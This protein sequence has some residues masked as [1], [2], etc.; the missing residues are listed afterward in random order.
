MK[1]CRCSFCILSRALHFPS[2][3]SDCNQ[4][5]GRHLTRHIR[6]REAQANVNRAESEKDR[7][8]TQRVRGNNKQSERVFLAL[9]FFADELHNSS[10]AP[11]KI[12]SNDFN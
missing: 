10:S 4:S 3:A 8:S 6:M 1:C 11:K 12:S 2:S 9:F 5:V 7:K